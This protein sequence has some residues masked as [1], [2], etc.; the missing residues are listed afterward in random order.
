[1]IKALCEI[2]TIVS[3]LKVKISSLEHDNRKLKKQIAKLHNDL[4]VF[5]NKNKIKDNSNE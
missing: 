4:K 5:M 3:I 1:M 2:E